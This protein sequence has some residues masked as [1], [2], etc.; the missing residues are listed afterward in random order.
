MDFKDQNST[1]RLSNGVE[2]PCIG[3]GMWQTPSDEVGVASVLSAFEAGYRHIDTA[4]AYRNEQCVGEAFRRSGVKRED[5]FITTKIWNDAH[6]YDL[7]MSSFEESLKKLDTSY[8]DLLLIHW[9][10]PQALRD[11]WQAAN[12]ETWKAMEELYR[13]G[14]VRAIGISNFRKHHIDALLET[15]EIP[16]MVNQIKHCP[17]VIQTEVEEYSRSK[18]MLL[19]AYSPLGT[20]RML[21]SE[22]MKAL[23]EKYDRSIAQICIR[24]GLQRGYLPLPKSITPSRIEENLRV[25]DFEIDED[26][27]NYIAGID[28]GVRNASNPDAVPF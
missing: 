5:V 12:A 17:G 25:F 3:F 16:P 11:R 8:V 20:G 2:I 13:A 26:D 18:G 9:P 15:A 23:S 28:A 24:W 21:E 27:M 14:R 6:S 22:E 4:Q 19:E 1:F 7:V 10:N